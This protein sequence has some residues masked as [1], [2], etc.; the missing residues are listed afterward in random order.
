MDRCSWTSLRW[1]FIS[2]TPVPNNVQNHKKMCFTGRTLVPVLYHLFRW[3]HVCT[4]IHL[5]ALWPSLGWVEHARPLELSWQS[6]RSVSGGSWVRVPQAALLH[7]CICACTDRWHSW[8]RRAYRITDRY[9]DRCD[10]WYRR[11]D[12][13]YLRVINLEPLNLNSLYVCT[14]NRNG[15]YNGLYGDMHVCT[16]NANGLY[17]QIYSDEW[18]YVGTHG[19]A[20]EETWP[21]AK[22]PPVG[23]EPTNHCLLSERS[24][25]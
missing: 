9:T 2:Q 6:A 25:N 17:S 8:Y 20:L 10:L 11:R 1:F 21:F 22:E 14:M 7:I 5:Q 3:S 4:Q 23:F 13:L 19:D 16:R 12:C 18:L 24:A 15:L